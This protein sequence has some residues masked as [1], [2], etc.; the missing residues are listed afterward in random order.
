MAIP[1][2]LFDGTLETCLRITRVGFDQCLLAAT[3]RHRFSIL[4]GNTNPVGESS[5]MRANMGETKRSKPD[6]LSPI[7]H[8]FHTVTPYFGIHRSA[9]CLRLVA[10]TI[11]FFVSQTATAINATAGIPSINTV[12]PFRIVANTCAG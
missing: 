5:L 2:S 7:P 1:I 4:V 11:A 10:F 9:E 8:R 3:L 12:G 6:G